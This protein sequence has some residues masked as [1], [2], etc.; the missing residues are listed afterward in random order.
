MHA[1]NQHFCKKLETEALDYHNGVNRGTE[2]QVK[3]KLRKEVAKI[4]AEMTKVVQKATKSRSQQKAQYEHK[5]GR[6]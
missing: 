4:Q 3:A 1:S 2:Q 6:L 5:L